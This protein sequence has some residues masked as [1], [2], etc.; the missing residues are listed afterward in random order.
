MPSEHLAGKNLNHVNLSG[1]DL[2]DSDLSQASLRRAHLEGAKLQN[3][4]LAGSDLQGARLKDADVSGAD[5]HNADLTEADL[6]GVDLDRAASTEGVRLAGAKGVPPEVAEQ[7]A[8]DRVVSVHWDA[9]AAE[10]DQ[11]EHVARVLARTG[12]FHDADWTT[13]LTEQ[14]RQWYRRDAR[15]AI[16]AVHD[17]EVTRSTDEERQ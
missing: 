15:A 13:G 10:D 16:K 6:R 12:G 14:E 1:T 2:S 3:A 4:N 5:L 7:A 11:V 17:Y 9:D 8:E